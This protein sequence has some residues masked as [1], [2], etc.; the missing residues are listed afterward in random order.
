MTILWRPCS[1]LLQFYQ[2]SAD[3]MQ[4]TN[5]VPHFMFQWGYLGH[6]IVF[7]P[8]L[9]ESMIRDSVCNL[10]SPPLGERDGQVWGDLTV[11]L[12]PPYYLLPESQQGKTMCLNK[13]KASAQFSG[14]KKEKKDCTQ[15]AHTA[16]CLRWDAYFL[17]N[18]ANSNNNTT[19]PMRKD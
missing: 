8:T 19:N 11:C 2:G 16:C 5:K 3:W 1:I 12:F 7:Q 17:G 15:K 4:I 10:P 14:L 9:Q 13:T 18:W 6:F